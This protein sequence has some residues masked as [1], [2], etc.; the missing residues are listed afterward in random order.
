MTHRTQLTRQIVTAAAMTLA[1]LGACFPG[2]PPSTGPAPAGRVT[3]HVVIVSIDGLRPDA[4]ERFGATTIQRLM[5]EGAYTLDARTI[6]PAKTL[7]SHTSMLTGVPPSVHGVDWNTDRTGEA[8]DEHGEVPTPDSLAVPTVFELAHDAGFVTAAFFSKAKFH[9]LQ[10]PG[11]LD[12]TQAPRLT[13]VPWG[14]ERTVGDAAAYVRRYRPNLVFVHIGEP[15]YAG[16][17]VGYMSWVY[18]E[19]VRI[20][21]RALERL[22]QA[23][24]D[25]YGA[26]DY[27]LIVTADHG[28][29][30]H[31]HGEDVPTDVTIPWIAYGEGVRAGT[32]LGPGVSTMDTAATAL[33]LLGVPVP[34]W[35]EGEPVERAFVEGGAGRGE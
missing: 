17:A 22:V 18:G 6:L 16:H 26:G 33:W 35:W 29:H 27:T 13:L 14:A 7:P 8:R 32:V 25:A 10:T 28:G 12:Y 21:D 20:A 1:A 11:S 34:E 3:Q 15:D 30:G 31:G 23:A 5:R 9:H 4:I 24:D 2:P 19:N